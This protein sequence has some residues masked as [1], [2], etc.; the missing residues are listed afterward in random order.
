MPQQIPYKGSQVTKIHNA[1]GSYFRIS[2][3]QEV[4]FEWQCWFVVNSGMLGYTQAIQRIYVVVQG[5]STIWGIVTNKG[6][7][8]DEQLVF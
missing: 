7:G 5:H 6:N 1:L 8:Y 4:R 3:R 2:Q